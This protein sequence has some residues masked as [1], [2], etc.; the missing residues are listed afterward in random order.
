M[1][2]PDLRGLRAALDTHWTRHGH[3]SAGQ[4]IRVTALLHRLT[5]GTIQGGWPT[6]HAPGGFI[7]TT[8]AHFHYWLELGGFIIDL[9]ADQFGDAPVIHT[10]APDPR[11]RP[12]ATP[13]DIHLDFRDVRAITLPALLR[14]CTPGDT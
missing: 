5:G 14:A 1:A 10:P 3:T 11:Y 4:C 12:C 7:T 8:G 13:E 9:T 6:P 2:F